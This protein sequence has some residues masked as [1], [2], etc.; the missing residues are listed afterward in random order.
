MHQSIPEPDRLA[1]SLFQSSPFEAYDIALDFL[2]DALFGQDSQRAVTWS[3]V[4][5][6]IEK[7]QSDYES[8]PDH[9]PEMRY[10]SMM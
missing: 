8:E 2:N 4:L 1:S 6:M 9:F 10:S 7:M 3:A 5:V